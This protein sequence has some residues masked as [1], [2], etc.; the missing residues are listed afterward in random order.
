MERGVVV[1]LDVRLEVHLREVD[2]V[3]IEAL[4]ER[5]PLRPREVEASRVFE[6]DERTPVDHRVAARSGLL[7]AFRVV[8]PHQEVHHRRLEPG[9]GEDSAGVQVRLISAA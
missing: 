5:L 8:F 4:Q 3:P 9:V 6:S 7:A 2:A 1:L